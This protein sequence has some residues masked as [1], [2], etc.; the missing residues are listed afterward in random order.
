VAG[1]AAGPLHTLTI[2]LTDLALNSTTV[3]NI[4]TQCWQGTGYANGAVTGILKPLKIQ[5]VDTLTTTSITVRVGTD[6]GAQTNVTCSVSGGVSGGTGGG[7]NVPSAGLVKSNG[8]VLQTAVAGTD[9]QSPIPANT[10]DA[11]GAASS[12]QTASLQKSSNLGD[13]GNAVTARTNLG[14]G[15]AATQNTSAFDSAGAAAAITLPGL[16]SASKSRIQEVNGDLWITANAYYDGTNWQR[17]DITKTAFGLQMQGTNNIP[18]GEVTPGTNLWV[19]QPGANPINTTYGSVG[20]WDLAQVLTGDRQ[21][22]IG[23]GGME[24]DGYGSVP[25]ARAMHNTINST[26]YTGFVRNLFPDFSGVD[27]N[28]D[29]SWFEGLVGDAFKVQRAAAGST[30]L[31]DLLTLNTSGLSLS[32]SLSVDFSATA[33]TLPSKKGLA[34]AKPATCT[35]GEEYFA[36]DATAGQNKYYC[37]ATNTWTQQSGTSMSSFSDFLSV[38]TGTPSSST[39]LGGDGVWK[40]VAPATVGAGGYLMPFDWVSG[41][42]QGPTANRFYV[43]QF[44]PRLSITTTKLDFSL[45]A[46][47]AGGV[48]FAL[49]DSNLNIL[50]ASTVNTAL[51]GNAALQVT[52]S[53]QTLV[54][55]QVYYLG[56]TS[57]TGAISVNTVTYSSAWIDMLNTSTT[58]V[59]YC[60]NPSTGSGSSL[61]FPSTCGSLTASNAIN[62]VASILEP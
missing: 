17:F 5:S 34:S 21:M 46:G 53:P 36:T 27:S 42:G 25:Y 58:R 15:S 30:T 54:A 11:Y 37:T 56:F 6:A 47:G 45:A 61:A 12:A 29:P 14:L 26:L 13:L 23:G 24:I 43:F 62:P 51:F 22:V 18:G 9:Y 31:S 20:G 4:Q 3:G 28:T 55:G 41:S 2:D 52:F 33:H 57:D 19:V 1:A 40:T 50:Q 8:T 44:I 60:A 32:P 7:A 48:R 16:M 59:G 10:Y 39:V 38:T 49:L 35:V